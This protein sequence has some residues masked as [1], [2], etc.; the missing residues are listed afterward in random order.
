[1]LSLRI[2]GI[3]L[4]CLW[5]TGCGGEKLVNV[6]GTIT[7]N[8]QPI[9]CGPTGYVEVV[10]I[11]DV[12]PGTPFTTKPGEADAS[13]NFAISG[14]KPGKYKIAVAVRDP[15]PGDDKIKGEF[16]QVNTK[17][18]REIDGQTPLVIELTAP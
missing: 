2:A 1:M 16:S 13:G 15:L 5:L 12:P 4:C 7:K 17:I 14:V 10:L 6:K 11:P 18:I 9:A 8:Q 3:A